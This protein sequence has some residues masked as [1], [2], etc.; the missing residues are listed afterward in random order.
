M[1]ARLRC[2]DPANWP[3]PVDWDEDAAVVLN[4]TRHWG[5][6][7]DPMDWWIN[8]ANGLVPDYRQ[9]VR[10]SHARIGWCR[11]NGADFLDVI[12]EDMAVRRGR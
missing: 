8:E 9:H 12:A 5:A 4:V 10:F 6:M 11:A 2:Y 7:E 1:P 3:D